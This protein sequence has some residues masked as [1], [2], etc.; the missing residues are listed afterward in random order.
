MYH[1][2]NRKTVKV[3]RLSHDCH[4]VEC[5]DR[6]NRGGPQ[7]NVKDCTCSSR[8][9]PCEDTPAVLS[10]GK[11]CDEKWVFIRVE[12]RPE[13]T[14]LIESGKFVLCKCDNFVPIVVLGL[15]E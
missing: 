4:H 14:H 3:L 6:H 9:K 12:G 8:S 11:L 7:S 5:V 2:K 15:V 1:Q 10:P 13:E